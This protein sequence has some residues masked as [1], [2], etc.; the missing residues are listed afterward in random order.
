MS[1]SHSQ[2]I[3]ITLPPGLLK[4]VD[5]LVEHN[6]G[7]RSTIIRNA[8]L[9]YVRQPSNKLIA[10]PNSVNIAKLYRELKAEHPYLNPDDAEL[11]QFLYE[12]RT[13]KAE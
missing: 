6:Y 10:N 5:R 13:K 9:D 7:N 4:Q 2:R 11:I 12:Q 3:N 1:S 8:L